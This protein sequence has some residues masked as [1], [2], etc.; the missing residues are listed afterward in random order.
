MHRYRK[1]TGG[2]RRGGLEGISEI[3]K[4]DKDVQM[5]SYKISHRDEMHS[6]WNIVSNI[7]L[8]LYD[9]R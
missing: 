6:M 7:I 8:T 5:S 4:G 2:C 3:G 1:Q 9:D